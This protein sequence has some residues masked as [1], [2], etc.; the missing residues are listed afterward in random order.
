MSPSLWIPPSRES[1]PYPSPLSDSSYD[2]EE[3][4]LRVRPHW[5][6]YRNLLKLR[7][8]RLETVGDAK[9]YYK[10]RQDAPSEHFLRS[11]KDMADDALCPDAG[12]VGF[13]EQVVREPYTSIASLNIYFV[14]HEQATGPKWSSR[15]FM[16]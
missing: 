7:G 9:Q 10:Q 14:G 11:C 3:V 12:L 4:N 15:P 8:Y 16:H 1:D 6:A 2:D 5:P 13:S